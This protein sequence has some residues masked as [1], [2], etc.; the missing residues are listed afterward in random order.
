MRVSFTTPTKDF[1]NAYRQLA[2]NLLKKL[3][4]QTEITN[5]IKSP[6]LVRNS[7]EASK[8]YENLA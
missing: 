2:G 5:E 7:E 4:L 1:E 8:S 6:N 3:M